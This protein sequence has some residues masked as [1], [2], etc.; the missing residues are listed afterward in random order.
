MKNITIFTNR[1]NKLIA[2]LIALVMLIGIIS[3]GLS[4]IFALPAPETWTAMTNTETGY[5]SNRIVTIPDTPFRG[6][7]GVN[8]NNPRFST[9]ENILTAAYSSENEGFTVFPHKA[10]KADL[11]WA[12]MELLTVRFISLWVKDK[13][14]IEKYAAPAAWYME[15]ARGGTALLDINAEDGYG[16]PANDKINWV[17][18]SPEIADV[19]GSTITAEDVNGMAYFV[20]TFVD[21]WGEDHLISMAV[22]VGK[23]PNANDFKFPEWNGSKWMPLEEPDGVYVKVT[24]D[25]KIKAP[26]EFIYAPGGDTDGEINEPVYENVIVDNG[27]DF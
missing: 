7:A 15:A 18:L 23:G 10:G 21:I 19:N 17:A 8:T 24:E 2:G 16:A 26:P 25:G 5:P 13:N 12:D 11:V 14:N 27:G 22:K 3:A 4:G 1:K 20:G 9:D 6:A